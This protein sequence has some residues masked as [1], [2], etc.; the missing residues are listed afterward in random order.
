[1]I[2]ASLY[3]RVGGDPVSRQT[4][5][6]KPM[7]T[8]SVAVNVARNDE[9]LA[10]EWFNVV[11]FG[12][13]ADELARHKKG[14]LVAVIGRLTRNNFTARDGQERSSWS[15]AV[16]QIVSART[17]RPGG[18]AKRAEDLFRAPAR[19]AGGPPLPQDNVDDLYADGAP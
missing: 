14:D 3:G 16:E 17:V 7:T 11:A 1:M 10:N 2:Y 15:V 5:T 8:C 13:T 12:R 4:R 9:E 19:P 6:G 18:R